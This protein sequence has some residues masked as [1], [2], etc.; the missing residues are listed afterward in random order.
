MSLFF[1][2]WGGGPVLNFRKLPLNKLNCL[3]FGHAWGMFGG[4][5]GDMF[6]RFG[7]GVLD[8]FGG[9]LGGYLGTCLDSCWE[10]L[11]VNNHIGSL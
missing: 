10:A 11:E 2:E 3:M 8:P 4:G 9:I 1:S 5:L 7:G 6:V